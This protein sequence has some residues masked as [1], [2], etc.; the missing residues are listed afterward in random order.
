MAESIAQVSRIGLK[1]QPWLDR[2]RAVQTLE[3]A[4][5]QISSP[6]CRM[7]VEIPWPHPGSQMWPQPLEDSKSSCVGLLP[8]T[9][10]NTGI[11]TLLRTTV[12]FAQATVPF[13]VSGDSPS[14]FRALLCVWYTV[15]IPPLPLHVIREAGEGISV[16]SVHPL[17]LKCSLLG[18][19]RAVTIS[20]SQ[21]H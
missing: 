16:Y 19:N 13:L 10:W 4:W 11:Q 8:S 20:T 7:A 3:R 1:P 2:H 18:E 6:R 15:L 9:L 14:C 12:L 21:N 17:E 5:Y